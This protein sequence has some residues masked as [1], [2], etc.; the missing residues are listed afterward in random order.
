MKQIGDYIYTVDEKYGNVRIWKI[1][2]I[3]EGRYICENK[4]TES[5]CEFAINDAGIYA[6]EEEAWKVVRSKKNKTSLLGILWVLILFG[7]LAFGGVVAI[8][9][10]NLDTLMYGK[11]LGF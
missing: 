6:T 5:I 2:E 7:V 4:R 3:H 9:L 10:A 8:I 11:S 1:R